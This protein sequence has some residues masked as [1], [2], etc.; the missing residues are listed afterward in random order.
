MTSPI[1]KKKETSA[2]THRQK[3]EG[4]TEPIWGAI[5]LPGGQRII[6]CSEDGSLRVW[7]VKLS[8]NPL[9]PEWLRLCEVVRNFETRLRLCENGWRS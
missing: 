4:H 3:F 2:I 5:H 8:E 6:T 1:R 7:N 9:F